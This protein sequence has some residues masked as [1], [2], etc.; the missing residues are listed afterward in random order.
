MSRTSRFIFVLSILL[1][2]Q[3]LLWAQ[4][5][6]DLA[7]G[8]AGAGVCAACGGFFIF[9]IIGIIALNIAILVWVTRDAKNRGMDNAVMWLIVV[10]IAGPIGLIVYFLS[11]P[12]GN[13]IQCSHCPNKRMETSAVCPHCG[14]A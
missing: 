4:A 2:S 14:H 8:A 11:R 6:E 13:L 7:A 3:V 1:L 10:L 5:D 9:I 12:K